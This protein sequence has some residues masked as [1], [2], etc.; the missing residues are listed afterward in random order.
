MQARRANASLMCSIAS[1]VALLIL[2][3]TC[4]RP[5]NLHYH[6]SSK[7]CTFFFNAVATN[8]QGCVLT[9]IQL[10]RQINVNT[11]THL[12]ALALCHFDNQLILLAVQVS[13]LLLDN[14]AEEL[15]LQSLLLHCKV[16]YHHLGADLRSVVRVTCTI[17][18]ASLV[19]CC[20]VPH[21]SLKCSLNAQASDCTACNT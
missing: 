8:G 2:S 13:P 19:D 7:W 21:V 1:C 12:R 15:G 11:A 16:D 10:H 18:T 6:Q 14:S 4:A 5:C 3:H 20:N 9:C 17:Q